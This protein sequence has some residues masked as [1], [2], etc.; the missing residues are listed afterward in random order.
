MKHKIEQMNAEYGYEVFT[1]P[2]A[3]WPKNSVLVLDRNGV[4]QYVMTTKKFLAIK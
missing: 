3:G 1:L 2:G 4:V